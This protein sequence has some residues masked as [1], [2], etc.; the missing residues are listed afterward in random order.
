MDLLANIHLFEDKNFKNRLSS[1]YWIDTLLDEIS[2]EE[3][4]EAFHSTCPHIVE[5]KH[6]MKIADIYSIWSEHHVHKA[7]CKDHTSGF[8]MDANFPARLGIHPMRI[9]SYVFGFQEIADAV[10]F[11]LAF[12]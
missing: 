3:L 1:R 10:M 11:R 8:W 7:W 4:A 5:V 2:S 9:F 6:H 12:C